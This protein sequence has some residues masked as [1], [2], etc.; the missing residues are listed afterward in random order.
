MSRTQFRRGISLLFPIL[1][2]LAVWSLP[3]RLGIGAE[4]AGAKTL[5]VSVMLNPG[6][7]PE[8]VIVDASHHRVYIGTETGGSVT[9]VDD[10]TNHILRTMPVGREVEDLALDP[11]GGKLYAVSS[12]LSRLSIIDTSTLR[13]VAVLQHQ[14][15]A[16]GVALDPSRHRLYVT[17]PSANAVTVIDTVT[18]K[19]IGTLKVPGQP[20]GIGVDTTLHRVSVGLFKL[21]RVDVIDESSDKIKG[22]IQ[23]GIR[24]VHPFRVVS[25]T[26]R[27]YVLNSGSSSLSIVDTRALKIVRTL[28][29]GRYPEGIDVEPA[30]QRIYVSNEGDPGTDKNSGHTASVIDLRS[31]RFIDTLSTPRGPDGIAFDPNTGDVYV[32]VE[33]SGR[34]AVI[35]LPAR[36]R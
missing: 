8:P 32:S 29:L 34:V 19:L 21:H 12:V 25:S 33:D 2:A 17:E 3:A 5:P 23:V 1:L 13:I 22:S 28:K 35:H 20:I 11:T 16:S 6:K 9:V 4:G 10:R 31:G 7:R 14:K 30:K 26:H 27:L 15:D 36:D 18:N 24:P